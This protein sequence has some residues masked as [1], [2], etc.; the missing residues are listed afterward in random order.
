VST[1]DFVFTVG[2]TVYL[3]EAAHCGGTGADT[4]TNGCTSGTVPL[5]TPVTI[6]AADVQA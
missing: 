3:A 2:A 1:G 4:E 6:D 5:S